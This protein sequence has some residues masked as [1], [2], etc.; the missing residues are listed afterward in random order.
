VLLQFVNAPNRAG[1]PCEVMARVRNHGGVRN[2]IRGIELHVPAGLRVVKRPEKSFSEGIAFNEFED[3]VWEVVA[4]QPGSY[5]VTVSCSGKGA[6]EPATASLLFSAPLGLPKADYVPVPRPIETTIDVCAY[7]FPGWYSYARWDCIR[8]VA[9]IRKPVLGYYDEAN[10]ECVDWQIKW[11]IENGISCFLVDWYWNQGA[12]SLR[13]WFDAYKKARYRDQL[14]VAIMWA[15]HNQPGSHSAEDWRAATKDWIENYFNLPG[16]YRIDGKP[17]VFIWAPSNIRR[18]LGGTEATARSYAESQKMAKA[19]GYEGITFVAMNS[20]SASHLQACVEEG[21]AGITTYHE[22]GRSTDVSPVLRRRRYEDVVA[23]VE[24]S[25]RAKESVSGE[26]TYYPVVDT[27]W[28]SRPWHGDEAMAIEGR[29]P[30]LFE[31]LLR[32]GKAYCEE[33]DKPFIVLGPLN[34]WGE[35]SYIEPATE[36]G[37]EMYERVR[38]VFGTGSPEVRP[39]NPERWPVNVAPADVG[40][41]GYSFPEPVATMVWNFNEGRGGWAPAM[42]V[43]EFRCEDGALHFGTSTRDPALSVATANLASQCPVAEVRMQVVGD[44]PEVCAAQMFWSQGGS[45]VTEATS[46]RFLLKTDG[47]MHTYRLDLAAHSRWRGRISSLRFDPC[48]VAGVQVVIDEF[49]FTP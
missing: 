19:A 13:H 47:E 48:D 30:E 23:T 36:Y 29:T 27:G 28:D 39:V 24:D 34:E 49:R 45:A 3:F 21:Y 44:M 42:G 35:G 38:K 16:Y 14:K 1:L 43:R 22:W 4:E 5:D 46:V 9:P 10:V 37:F 26:L 18:D 12:E 7:Y 8:N 25:W 15:N 31:E 6:P 33:H 41:G 20:V 32:K 40:L 11:A 17:A 2:G